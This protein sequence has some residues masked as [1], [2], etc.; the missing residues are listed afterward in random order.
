[1]ALIDNQVAYW[2]LDNSLLDSSGNG[3]TLSNSGST[4]GTGKINNGIIFDGVNNYVSLA[5]NTDFTTS[6]FSNNYWVRFKSVSAQQY[7]MFKD[8]SGNV[9]HDT[10]MIYQ[11]S[12]DKLQWTIQSGGGQA[13]LLTPLF[14]DSDWHMITI[15][16]NGTTD[17]NIYFDGV[18]SESSALNWTIN[19]NTQTLYFGGWATATN[20]DA[21]IDEIGWWNRV[22]TSTEVL[23]LYNSGAGLQYPYS[24]A[25]T[26]KKA[27][28][29]LQSL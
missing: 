20:A 10:S 15:T 19:G 9:N 16:S 3:H 29:M 23:E 14:T 7:I 25:A 5:H 2:K 12:L 22:L 24:T 13:L 6:T 4:F 18:L 17:H 8:Q 28:F 21:D 27:L 26:A 1:M 11:P